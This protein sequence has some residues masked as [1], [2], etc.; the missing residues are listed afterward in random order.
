[1]EKN[2][3]KSLLKYSFCHAIIEYI[4]KEIRNLD[5][6]TASQHDPIPTKIIK[7]N[8]GIS[9]FIFHNFITR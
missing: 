9:W 7:E 1:M 4:H 2:S 6:S 3:S 8:L 5:T